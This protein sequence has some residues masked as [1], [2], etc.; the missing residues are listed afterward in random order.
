MEFLLS[1]HWPGNVGQLE[2]PIERAC[3]TSRD[4][5][6]HLETLPPDLVSP[7]GP[8][9]PFRIDLERPL[10]SVL[11]EAINSI[12]HQYIRKALRK[13]R[14]NVGRCAKIS[15]LSRRSITAKIPQYNL[16]KSLL[17]EL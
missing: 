15:G 14:G 2:N 13:A 1:C 9:L 6:I 5:W 10:S 12:E 11:R 16:H 17:K 4:N 8:Q 3:V 7:P